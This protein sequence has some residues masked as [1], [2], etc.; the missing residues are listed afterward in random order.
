[1]ISIGSVVRV[2]YD[3]QGEAENEE[4]RFRSRNDDYHVIFERIFI[5]SVSSVKEGDKLTVRFTDVGEGWLQC[6]DAQGQFSSRSIKPQSR[7]PRINFKSVLRKFRFG[8]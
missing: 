8:P 3:F 5:I 6:E 4:L 7:D 2:A 1:M